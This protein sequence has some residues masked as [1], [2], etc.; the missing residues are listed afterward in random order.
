MIIQSNVKMIIFNADIM[1][2][3]KINFLFIIKIL[4]RILFRYIILLPN[5]SLKE[6]F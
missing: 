5:R 2:E 6:E 3:Q 4:N 1:L